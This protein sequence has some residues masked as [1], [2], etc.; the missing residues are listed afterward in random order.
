MDPLSDVLSLLKPRS[1]M[2]RGMDAGGAWSLRFPPVEGLR[3]YAP[4]AG[5]CWLS[6]EGDAEPI[7]LIAGDCV[8]LS[9]SQTFCLS[10][11]TRL[12]SVDAVDVV[13]AAPS[14][15]VITINGGGEV[16]GLGGFFRFEGRHAA[17]LLAALQPVVHIRGESD[18]AMLRAS[19]E[20]M[21]RELRE[22]RPG[23]SLVAQQLGQVMLVLALRLHLAQ[24]TGL[25]WLYALADKQMGAVISAM[26]GD[27]A[28]R[29]TLQSLAQCACMSRSAFAQRFRETVGESP[30]EYL[31]RWRMMLA[32]ERLIRSSDSV[33]TIAG[34]LGYQSESA[35]SA[36]FRRVMGCTPGQYRVF[37]TCV[38]P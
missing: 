6:I 25:G 17:V 16:S 37:E 30:M 5:A 27:P 28:R 26:H 33:A 34:S 4:L 35:F 10:S 36:A 22:P 21:M 12:K 11:D 15:G 32:G 2:F 1:Y 24:S 9:R 38:S 8:L 20:M 31:I 18:K 14:G 29:W 13:S 7:R 19:M 23:A 3:C